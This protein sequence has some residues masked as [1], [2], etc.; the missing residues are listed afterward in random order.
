VKKFAVTHA[1]VGTLI[2]NLAA[3]E[4][5]PAVMAAH[6]AMHAVENPGTCSAC[7]K[8]RRTAATNTE[9]INALKG[10]SDLELDRL[11]RALDVETFVFGVGLG[12]VER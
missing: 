9:L 6:T 2:D 4:A 12:F 1:T 10:A 3:R 7:A 8:R 5:S 11:K